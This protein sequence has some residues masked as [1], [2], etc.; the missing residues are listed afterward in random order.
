MTIRKRNVRNESVQEMLWDQVLRLSKHKVLKYG[1]V[2]GRFG[3][4]KRG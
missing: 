4:C 3:R 1:V 2:E